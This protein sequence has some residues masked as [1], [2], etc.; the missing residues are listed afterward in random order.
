MNTE[1]TTATVTT[2]E[3]T[4]SA[5]GPGRPK[6][7]LK[8]PRGMFTVE[9]LYELNRGEKGRGKRA[10]VCR[11]TVRN[12]IAEQVASGFLT[13]VASVDSGKP[14]QPAHRYLRTAVKAA[15]DAARAARAA[16]ATT[17]TP[18]ETPVPEASLVETPAVEVPA[19]AASVAV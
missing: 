12:H 16:A 5:K 18:T 14:G 11:L 9:E 4:K 7:V 15:A 17:E 10:K 8:Y 2:T 13:K 1:T 6:A 3:A 19:E